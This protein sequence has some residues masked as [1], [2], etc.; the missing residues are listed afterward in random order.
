MD[1]NSL[2]YKT[3]KNSSY[4]FAGF[5]LPM[6]FGIFVTRELAAKLGTVEFGV[7][8]LLNA[9][10]SFIG[11]VD[12]GLGTAITKF[13]AEYHARDDTNSL[14]NLLGSARVIFFLT[15]ILGLA[16]FAVLGKWF[17]PAF[18]IPAQSYH[19]IFIVF[20]LS[21]LVFFFNSINTVHTAVLSSL[22]RFDLITKLGTL[23]LVAV[24]LGSIILLRSGFQLKAVMALNVASVFFQI[25]ALRYYSRRLL[26]DLKIRF[27]M[28]RN[29]VAKAYKFGLQTFV[30]GISDS[31]LVF[32][33]RLVIPIFLGPSQLAFYSVPGNVALKIPQ[34]TNSLTGMFFPMASALSGTGQMEKLKS[35]YIRAFRNLSVIAMAITVA[36]ILFAN[37]ILFF[38][39]GADYANNGTEVLQ[40]L[41]LVYYLIAL[42][43][44]LRNMLLGLGEVKLLIRQ[45]IIMAVINVILLFIAVPRYGIVGAAWAYLF[46]VLP[47]IFTFYWVERKLFG[48]TGQGAYY[49]KLYAKL[50]FT[51]LAAS[52]IIY[53]GL[54]PL[55][56]NI[57]TLIILGPIS[58]LLYPVLYLLFGFV[59]SE[60]KDLFKSYLLSLKERFL[61][62]SEPL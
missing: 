9:I 17:L 6:F 40:V 30:S 23:N 19:N 13:A 2:S 12:L 38:W 41:A 44:P 47:M 55:V 1:K 28:V 33:D 35:I 39:L 61:G 5:L 25:L 43:N 59:D 29:E 45:S 48:I 24:S 42:Y 8:L 51:A 37:K 57:W 10:N 26:P 11:Y 16:I 4:L 49:L 27:A 34:V 20:I 62:K 22:Q 18:N 53:F 32:L 14:Q 52:L 60:D 50:L 56:K 15:G 21:G 7:F 54:L 31:C 58:V 36:I 46:S 3:L